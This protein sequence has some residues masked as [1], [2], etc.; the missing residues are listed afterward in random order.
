MVV[1]SYIDGET[2]IASNLTHEKWKKKQMEMGNRFII[3]SF[4]R[5]TARAAAHIRSKSKFDVGFHAVCAVQA[6][7][8]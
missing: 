2:T 3:K 8:I 4:L 5:G 1:L 6:N 7:R